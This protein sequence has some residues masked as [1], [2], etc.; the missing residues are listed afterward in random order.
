[1]PPAP[2]RGNVAPAGL[3]SA[4]RSAVLLL[5]GLLATYLDLPWKAVALVPL[6][7]AAWETVRALRDMSRAGAPRR[8]MVCLAGA[9]T[10][11]ARAHCQ[12]ELDGSFGTRLGGLG[13]GR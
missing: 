8:A 13:L 1:M 11:V 5:L 3:A 4:R 6:T 12:N 2:Q 9:N 7:L 10:G